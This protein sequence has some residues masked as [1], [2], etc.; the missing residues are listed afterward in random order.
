LTD[1]SEQIDDPIHR[2]IEEAKFS[3]RQVEVRGPDRSFRGMEIQN[4]A[5]LLDESCDCG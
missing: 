3:E 1:N 5:G 2:Y 4:Q